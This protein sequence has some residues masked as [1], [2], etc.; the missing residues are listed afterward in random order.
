M[1][2]LVRSWMLSVPVSILRSVFDESGA[3]RLVS[4]FMAC[5]SVRLPLWVSGWILLV[6]L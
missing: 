5:S 6:S 2:I 4:C 3:S 1:I